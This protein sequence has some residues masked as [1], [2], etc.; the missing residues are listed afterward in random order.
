MLVDGQVSLYDPAANPVDW[1]SDCL[2]RNAVTIQLDSN[3]QRTVAFRFDVGRRVVLGHRSDLP[4]AVV[5]RDR[6]QTQVG[7]KTLDAN[8]FL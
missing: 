2:H 5:Q 1:V 6:K 8:S 7:R 4:T 3:P